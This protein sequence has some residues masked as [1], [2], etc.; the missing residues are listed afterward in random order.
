MSKVVNVLLFSS[1]TDVA[2]GITHILDKADTLF[3]LQIAKNT[4]EV[5]SLLPLAGKNGNGTTLPD[6]VLIDIRNLSD[7]DCRLESLVAR[8][9]S[10][11]LFYVLFDEDDTLDKV[12]LRK[13][14]V[15]GFIKKPIRQEN[16]P[17]SD[18]FNFIIDV[19]NVK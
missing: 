13:S 2:I 17:R 14:G 8:G 6:I 5:L 10:N 16:I 11:L 3:K 15:S 9:N 18:V 1:D 12:A 19:R 7:S 4:T